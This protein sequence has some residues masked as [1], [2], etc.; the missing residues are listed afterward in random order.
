MR[1]TFHASGGFGYFPG[2]D[3]PLTIDTAALPADQ[4]AKLE[5]LVHDADLVNRP[6]EIGTPA[7]GAADYRTYTISID[8]GGSHTVKLTDPIEDPALLALVE[9]LT[10]EQRSGS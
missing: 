7:P 8:N 9:H 5:K 1:I 3:R 6:N 2:L 10:A 4:A